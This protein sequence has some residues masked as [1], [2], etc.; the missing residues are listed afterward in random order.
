MYIVSFLQM[1]EVQSHSKKNKNTAILFL[2]LSRVFGESV[3]AWNCNEW[4]VSA[5]ALVGFFLFLFILR[6]VVFL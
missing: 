1:H 2:F 4:I 6:L 3:S 5:I